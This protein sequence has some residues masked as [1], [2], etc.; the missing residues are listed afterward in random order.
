[1]PPGLHILEAADMFARTERHL[2]VMGFNAALTCAVDAP[3]QPKRWVA[4]RKAQRWFAW[5]GGRG[6]LA[7]VVVQ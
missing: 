2:L 1:M 5:R 7:P 3:R 6:G 4:V